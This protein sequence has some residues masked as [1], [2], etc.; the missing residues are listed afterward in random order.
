MKRLLHVNISKMFSSIYFIC[1]LICS[2]GMAFFSVYIVLNLSSV[3]ESVSENIFEM[4][5][6]GNAYNLGIVKINSID[7]LASVTFSDIIVNTLNTSGY[8]MIIVVFICLFLTSDFRYGNIIRYISKGFSRVAIYISYILACCIFTLVNSVVYLISFTV[9]SAVLGIAVN[10]SF[11]SDVLY[12]ILIQN[13]MLMAFSVMC[14]TIVFTLRKSV[15]SLLTCFTLI[16]V[17][18]ETFSFLNILYGIEI[19]Y[20]KIWLLS[21]LYDIGT[22]HACSADIAVIAVTV[23]FSVA[24]GVL[25]S[26]K[27]KIKTI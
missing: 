19:P 20:E 27:I 5:K 15:S 18:P 21:R 23:F 4:F 25:V 6:V 13:V 2:A 12:D 8:Q 10:F 1:S 14:V 7:E 16:F 17:L 22:V 26:K 3:L 24:A 11:S 9:S